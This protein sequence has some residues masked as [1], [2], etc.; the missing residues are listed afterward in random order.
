MTLGSLSDSEFRDLGGIFPK[1][2]SIFP[3]YKIYTAGD[4]REA[5]ETVPLEAL[6]PK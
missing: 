1:P 4:Y 6:G 3:V 5:P 2:D